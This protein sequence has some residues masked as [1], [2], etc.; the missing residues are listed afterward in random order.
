[1]ALWL[2]DRNMKNEAVSLLNEHLKADPENIKNLTNAVR[3]FSRMGEK[4]KA[5]A[6]LAKLKQI[7]PS[8]PEVK[9]LIGEMA[10]NKGN[11][12]EAL[13]NYEDALRCDPKNLYLIEHLANIYNIELKWNNL[14]LHYRLALDNYPNEPSLL[15]GLSRVL[16]SCPDTTLK[17]IPEGGAYAERAFI[18]FKSPNLIK[19]SAGANLATAY[20][21]LG[22][23]QKASKY[24]SLATNLARKENV[25][26]N[27]NQYFET[28]REQ[29]HISK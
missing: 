9:K 18:N 1:M 4:E 29:Y 6:F 2:F 11:L 7:S 13:A 5:D 16:I 20:A 8:S 10:E 3:L 28:L 23:K 22:D 21:I 17:N 19:I 15:E 25:I 14:I 12:K 24:I 26:Q 27:Y